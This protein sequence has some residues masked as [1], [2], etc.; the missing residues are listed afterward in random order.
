MRKRAVLIAVVAVTTLDAC[1]GGGDGSGDGAQ[2]APTTAPRVAV[3]ITAPQ[4]GASVAPHVAVR[5]LVSP[6]NATVDVNGKAVSVH[7]GRFNATVVLKKGDAQ[8]Q[9]TAAAAGVSD[10]ATVAVKR[11]PSAAEKQAAARR[12]AAKARRRQATKNNASDSS[13]SDGSFAMPN[14]VGANL[15]EA[16]DDIQRASGDPLF[17]SHSRDA[18]GADRFQ[19]L[20]RD[21]KVCGQNVPPGQQVSAVGHIVFTVVKD[22]EDCP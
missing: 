5:G 1:G 11:L 14:E 4:E 12:K 10:Q 15:Q 7:A 21:W 17:V 13:Q 9:A 22:Y 20:D 3:K 2:A 18:T 6:N 16:Q 8:L 19:V